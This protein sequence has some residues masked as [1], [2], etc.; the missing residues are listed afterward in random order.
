MSATDQTPPTKRV[1]APAV[2]PTKEEIAAKIA[3]LEQQQAATDE[4]RM[5]ADQQCAHC[6]AK[7]KGLVIEIE[8]FTKLLASDRSGAKTS[9]SEDDDGEARPRKRGKALMAM[10][11]ED[12]KAKIAA[13]CEQQDKYD[14]KRKGEEYKF[15]MCEAKAQG[16]TL[17]LEKY[18]KMLKA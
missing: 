7:S 16:I 3:K 1:R 9:E 11:D 6:N 5:R 12:I 2:P 14:T 8:K 17:E 10:S 18:R 13:L 4:K 15:A